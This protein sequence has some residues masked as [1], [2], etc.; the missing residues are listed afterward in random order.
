VGVGE[1]FVVAGQSNAANHGEEKQATK[2]GRVVAFDGQHWQLCKRKNAGRA[3]HF[4]GPGL[5][6]HAAC[7]VEKVAPWLENSSPQGQKTRNGR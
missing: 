3:V 5:P 2:S 4:S 1:I 6:V 7:W